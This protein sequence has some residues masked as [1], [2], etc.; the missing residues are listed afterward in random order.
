MDPRIGRVEPLLLGSGDWRGARGGG[1]S[2]TL[3]GIAPRPDGL[4]LSK[5]V[6]P[7]ERALL[8][9]PGAVLVDEG[10]LDKLVTDIGQRAEING[11]LIRWWAPPA[12]CAP[13]GASMWWPPWARRGCWTQPRR[14]RQRD[15][16]SRQG[17]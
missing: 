11:H 7:E 16:L 10:D 14:L 4:G 13:W 3:V 5:A 1:T 15:L 2:I 9:E 8:Q 12:T 6:P 17:A